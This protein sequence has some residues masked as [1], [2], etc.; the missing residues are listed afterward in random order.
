M[1]SFATEFP[2]NHT[3][4]SP[5]F[6]QAIRSWVLGSPHTRFAVDDL[7]NIETT[8]N[9]SAQKVNERINALR[10]SSTSEDSAAVQYI[11]HDGDLEWNT[12]IVFSKQQ[13]DSWISIRVSCE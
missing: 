8:D 3:H 12:S 1:L 2:I 6:L 13:S 5:A 10:I 7:A 11:R 4:G 9:W